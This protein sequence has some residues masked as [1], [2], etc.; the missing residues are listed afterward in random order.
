MTAR[1]LKE[2]Y[3]SKEW[4][5]FRQIVIAD[6]MHED[7]TVTDEVTGETIIH[8]YDLILHHKTELTE[9]NFR[10]VSISL[11]PE[12]IQIIS[13]RTHNM[14]HQR[15]GF[16]GKLVQKVYIVY[17]SPCAGKSTWVDSVAQSGDLILDID[18][19]WQA[20]RAGTCGEYD[21][22]NEIKSVVFAMRDA[23]LDAIQTRRGKWGSAFVIGGYPMTG[24]R[25]RLQ[26]R[27][28]ADD[29]IFI[30]TPKDVCLHRAQQ[31]A[32]EW[33]GFVEDWFEKFTASGAPPTENF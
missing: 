6:R 31:K 8:K 30:D 3:S 27:L 11:N 28:G 4:E 5:R 32:P 20:A 10:D 19:L 24:E 22:P 23:M 14:L 26:D 17:G 2:F 7:G 1:T 15:F 16:S 9:D 21:K 25:E 13:F 33:I 18:R 12:N 29:V